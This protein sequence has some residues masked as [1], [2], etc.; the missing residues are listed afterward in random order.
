VRTPSIIQ[1]ML[2]NTTIMQTIWGW[3][4]SVSQVKSQTP[5]TLHS[6]CTHMQQWRFR[7]CVSRLWRGMP[8]SRWAQTFWRNLQSPF[9]GCKRCSKFVNFTLNLIFGERPVNSLLSNILCHDNLNNA[10]C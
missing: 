4:T 6:L 9:S 3:D 5:A 8:S 1:A 7:P 2:R 10:Q